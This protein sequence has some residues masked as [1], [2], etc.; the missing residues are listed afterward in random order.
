[1]L[2]LVSMAPRW[3]SQSFLVRL[4]TI[5]KVLAK[6]YIA[7]LRR[8]PS[9]IRAPG[10]AATGTSGSGRSTLPS[11]TNFERSTL[12]ALGCGVFYTLY[13]VVNWPCSNRI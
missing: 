13:V 1:M 9:I 6:Q 3:N 5:E 7:P 11:S 10:S 8:I 4:C 12:F 2:F